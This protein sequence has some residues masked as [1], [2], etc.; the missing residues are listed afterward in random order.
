MRDNEF[1]IAK[2]GAGFDGLDRDGN[3][4]LTEA[5][6]VLMGRGVAQG[7]GHPAGSAE[8]QAVIDAYLRI[9][10]E[11]HLPMDTDGDGRISRAEFT[12]ATAALAHDAERADTVLGGLADRIAD[13]ADRDGDGALDLAEYTAFVRGQAPG[14][15][16]E[17]VAEAFGHL[18]RDGDGRLT[19]AE[20][21]AAVVEYFT[22][23]DPT[24]PGSWYFGS[25]PGPR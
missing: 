25:P 14:L 9:W 8:E 11:L 24:A 7:L 13:L 3:G 1:V 2:I 22:S 19:R 15:A 20:L 21:R 16:P 17:E 23:P 4:V 12:A 18:D 10:R 6:H 5:D